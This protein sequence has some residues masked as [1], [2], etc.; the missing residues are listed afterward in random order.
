MQTNEISSEKLYEEIMWL[1]DDLTDIQRHELWKK[2]Y[3]GQTV[4]WGGRVKEINERTGRSHTWIE[5]C[6]AVDGRECWFNEPLSERAYYLGFSVGDEVALTGTLPEE[7]PRYPRVSLFFAKATIKKAPKRQEMIEREAG[8]CF[9]A[10]AAYGN[11]LD[12][13]VILLREFRDTF[14]LVS[15]YG[16][17]LVRTYYLISPLPA[18]VIRR[19][20]ILRW[21]SRVLLSPVVWLV[22]RATVRNI[23]GEK[24]PGRVE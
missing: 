9:I 18:C 11:S 20:R 16:Q 23:G 24:E 19:S 2:K 1:R 6:V 22:G 7:C 13:K 8:K 14:L 15:G 17:K 5:V 4:A 10:T 21:V 12:S 3:G